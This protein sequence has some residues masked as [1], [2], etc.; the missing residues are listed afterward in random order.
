MLDP[1]IIEEIKRREQRGRIEQP[2]VE[3]PV[4]G[5]DGRDRGNGSQKKEEEDPPRGVTII[6]F[7]VA[8]W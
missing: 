3:I 4:Q 6:D 1:W 7:G 2:V 5:P 8:C